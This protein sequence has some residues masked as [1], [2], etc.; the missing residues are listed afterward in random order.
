MKNILNTCFFGHK[1]SKWNVIKISV[2]YKSKQGYCD[3]Q[4]R[5]CE[6]C[7]KIQEEMI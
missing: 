5:Q 3:G 6:R 4:R 1:W 7:G 2:I